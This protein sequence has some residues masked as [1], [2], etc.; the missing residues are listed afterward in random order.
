MTEAEGDRYGPAAF[1]RLEPRAV[2]Q[3]LMEGVLLYSCLSPR[4]EVSPNLPSN[5]DKYAFNSLSVSSL[6]DR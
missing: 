2:E 3:I 1:G 6:Q 4:R 5:L